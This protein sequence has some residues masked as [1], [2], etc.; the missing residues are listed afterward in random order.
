MKRQQ[1]WIE[2]ILSLEESKSLAKDSTSIFLIF[3]SAFLFSLVSHACILTSSRL[4]LQMQN[5][6]HIMNILVKS[7]I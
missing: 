1:I 4:N 2:L 6:Q 3:D 5:N 7:S